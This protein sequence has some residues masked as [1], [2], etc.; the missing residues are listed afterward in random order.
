MYVTS[1]HPPIARSQAF[2]WAGRVCGVALFAVWAA[3]VTLEASRVTFAAW[4]VGLYFQ[5]A[6]LA[7]VFLG[8]AVG[9]KGELAGAVLVGV[10][11]V[12][13]FVITVIDTKMLPG[14]AVAWFVTPGVLYLFAR[15]YERIENSPAAAR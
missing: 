2:R 15:H 14:L 7:V 10:G 8:Y 3:F 4:P 5:G 13:F 1:H 11:A 12:A 9:W 6:A